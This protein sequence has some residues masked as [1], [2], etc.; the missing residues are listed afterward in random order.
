MQV[1]FVAFEN[2]RTPNTIILTPSALPG[3]QFN[4]PTETDLQK[5]LVKVDYQISA[6]DHLFVR[7]GYSRSF[8][9]ASTGS[10]PSAAISELCSSIHQDFATADWSHVSSPTVLHD[11]KLQYFFYH[12]QYAPASFLPS[13][14]STS[15]SYSFPGLSIG[16]PS[17][18]EQVWN[19]AFL[20]PRYDLSWR[21]G[22]HDI[23]I[24]F[25][26]RFG[27]DY[28]AY[29]K[30]LN[31]TYSFSKLPAN[32][33]TLL[34][35]LAA[36]D[37]S[38]WNFSSLDSIATQ[39]A[40]TYAKSS[41]FDVPRPMISAWIGDN[42]TGIPKLALNFGVRYDV[43]WR[44]LDPPNVA[45]TSIPITTGYGPFG[46]QDVGFRNG[47]RD[48]RDVAPRLGV[49]WSPRKDL[50]IR[51]GTGLYFAGVGEQPVDDQLYNGNNFITE[52][53]C[54]QRPAELDIESNGR[55]HGRSG[56][57]R[58]GSN[59]TTDSDYH[60]FRLSDAL[61]VAELDRCSEADRTVYE[62]R[63]RSCV[64]LRIPSR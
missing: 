27:K 61:L 9:T 19:E 18:G 40:I 46:T 63:L 14:I 45:P 52:T 28:G 7:W 36:E 38:Q 59:I 12:W 31:G 6:N 2:E 42:W 44:D 58:N 54:K 17:N 53:F 26:Y 55:R 47:I 13:S 39:Y 49:A 41:S 21:K 37:P 48:L 16:M 62:P 30:N 35:V 33:T 20:Q 25:E 56:V 3:E 43:A 64:V 10:V 5:P 15:P 23:K 32:I 8:D 24:G 4:L 22:K 29:Y 11:L 60:C 1:Y 34:P 50:V 57:C 51:G